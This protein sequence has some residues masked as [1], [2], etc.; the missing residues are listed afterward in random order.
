MSLYPGESFPFQDSEAEAGFCDAKGAHVS[1]VLIC[2]GP[3]KI[4]GW[5]NLPCSYVIVTSTKVRY[6]NCNWLRPLFPFGLPLSSL[7][8]LCQEGVGLAKGS[9]GS[10]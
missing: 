9:F 3:P 7:C 1:G 5:G 2:T 8:L 4:Q 6:Y 10:S